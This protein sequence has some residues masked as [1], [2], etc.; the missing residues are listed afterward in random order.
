MRRFRRLR[1]SLLVAALLPAVLSP[2]P[3]AAA[4]QASTTTTPLEQEMLR[5]EITKLRLENA[6]LQKESSDADSLRQNLLAWAPFATTLLAAAGVIGT[7]AKGMQGLRR[8]RE[9]D[10]EQRE[11]ELEQ[12]KIENERRFGE[13]FAEAV[14]N[15]GSDNLSV[16]LSGAVALQSFLRPHWSPFYDQVL[17]VV[18]ANLTAEHDPRVNRILVRTF[19]TALRLHEKKGEQEEELDLTNCQMPRVNLTGRDLRGADLA[20]ATLTNATLIRANLF[21]AKGFQVKL[22]GAV[23][24][25]AILQEVRW[26]NGTCAGARFHRAVAYS[27]DSATRIYKRPSSIAPSSSRRISTEP[28]SRDR[29]LMTPISRTRTSTARPSTIARYGASC[30]R[31]LPRSPAR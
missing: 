16:R 21:R 30:A 10:H 4:V 17:A 7:A 28:G 11:R 31:R 1:N 8:Q 26:H 19:S 27:A 13:L 5:Q 14:A 18:Q 20:F 25:D 15:L 23:L 24:S 2:A 9:Q 22:E 3:I 6:K 29:G 12:R